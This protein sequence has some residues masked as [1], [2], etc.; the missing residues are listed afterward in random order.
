[1]HVAEGGPILA[2]GNSTGTL[3]GFNVGLPGMN[4]LFGGSKFSDPARG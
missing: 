3:S 2:S 4:W 1:M